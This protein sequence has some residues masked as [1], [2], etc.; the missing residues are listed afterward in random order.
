MTEEE[1]M[2]CDDPWEMECY[3][4]PLHSAGQERPDLRKIGLLCV[5]C[6]RR[7][8]GLMTA[9][10]LRSI[11]QF[12]DYVE[13]DPT[14]ANGVPEPAPEGESPSDQ[15]LR[16]PGHQT[17]ARFLAHDTLY[18]LWNE[19][20]T[21]ARPVYRTAEAA[22]AHSRLRPDQPFRRLDLYGDGSGVDRDIPDPPP[23]LDERQAQADLFREVFGNPFRPPA[24]DRRW[25]TADVIG[26]A[27]GIYEDRAF[28]RLPIL[29]DALTD[30]GCDDADILG[31]CRSEGPH[32]RG[33]W[34]VDLVLGK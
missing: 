24:F 23:A 8:S 33:C 15:Y 10:G 21:W 5:A 12:E 13:G 2:I 22:V 17:A 32:V 27:G 1:W 11:N 14:A 26:L 25:R 30:V 9:E 31:H 29:A 34:V 6:C 7:L 3:V 28:D 16:S 4:R 18:F 20:E 19:V